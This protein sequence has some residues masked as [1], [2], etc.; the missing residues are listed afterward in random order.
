MSNSDPAALPRLKKAV[1]RTGNSLGLVI[2][3]RFVKQVG[4]KPG[5]EVEVSY[6]V[7]RGEI[8]YRIVSRRQLTLVK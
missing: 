6:D 8:C 2:P 1:I 5:D 3:S 4:I 7:Y